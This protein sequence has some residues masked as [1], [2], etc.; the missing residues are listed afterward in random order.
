MANQFSVIIKAVEAKKKASVAKVV[1]EITS[2]GVRDAKVLMDSLGVVTKGITKKK[3]EEIKAKLEDAGAIVEILPTAK[4]KKVFH[5]YW[6]GEKS[7]KR[8]G[9]SWAVSRSL[10]Q[11][12]DL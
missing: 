8:Q 2:L 11:G 9:P 6:Q 12:S 5:I 4:A 10:G 1:R 3:A 7:P